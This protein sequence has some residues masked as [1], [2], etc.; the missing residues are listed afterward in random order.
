MMPDS[1]T[2]RDA[3]L[4]PRVALALLLA[5]IAAVA[6]MAAGMATGQPPRAPSPFFWAYAAQYLI[7]TALGLRAA[8]FERPGRARRAW[9]LLA[10]ATGSTALTVI[11]AGLL[12][13]TDASALMALD[14]GALVFYPLVAAALLH[15]GPQ[16]VGRQARVVLDFAVVGVA[17][18]TLG[19]FFW[20]SVVAR[21]PVVSATSVLYGVALPVAAI[22]VFFAALGLTLRYGPRRPRRTD[23]LVIAGV[24][25]CTVTDVGSAFDLHVGDSARLGWALG[26]LLLAAA[27]WQR[28][29]DQLRYGVRLG[30]VPAVLREPRAARA[31]ER[32]S[33]LAYA[34][35]GAVGLALLIEVLPALSEAARV[36]LVGG[37]ALGVVLVVREVTTARA[38]RALTRVREQEAARFRALVQRASEGLVI[39]GLDGT[40]RYHTEPLTT[41]TG[42]DAASLRH[43]FDLIHSGDRDRAAELLGMLGRVVGTTGSVTVRGA[44]GRRTLEITG[45]NRLDEPAIAGIVLGVR[46]ATERQQ[47]AVQLHQAQKMDGLGRL[48]GGIAHDFNNLLTAIIGYAQ[49]AARSG[50]LPDEVSGP[51]REITR[52]GQQAAE[53]TRHLLAF[54]RRQPLAPRVV[55]FGDALHEMTQML[56]RLLRED[57]ELRVREGADVPSVLADPVQLQQMVLNLAVNARDAMP[58][59]G[60][61]A[62]TTERFV[63]DEAYLRTHPEASP[64]LHAVLRVEDTGIGMTPQVQA[65]AFE[66]FFTTKPEGAGTGLGLATVYG[67]VRQAGGHITVTSTPGHG[68][69][70]RILLPAAA[71]VA[72]APRPDLEPRAVTAAEDAGAAGTALLVEDNDAVRALAAAALRD[73]GFE[74]IAVASGTQALVLDSIRR[75]PL[76]LLVTDVVMPGV[77]GIELARTLRQRYPSLPVLFA[78]AYSDRDPVASLDG[79]APTALLLK[80]FTAEELGAASRRLVA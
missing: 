32:P 19:A 6:A 35:I 9:G 74:V 37:L 4:S 57:V 14:A 58:D 47:L 67:V 36:L 22:V 38:H 44:D 77:G 31:S 25:L 75:V 5:Q 26:T 30:G 56:G 1:P 54:S 17:T 80:P 53:L 33:S 21:S 27:A 3:L 11:V 39:V 34:G 18:L 78:T 15:L 65:R 43:L 42:L 62:L 69:T 40:V 46:D 70:F 79:A 12:R 2:T 71:G 7:A 72:A 24:M 48:A 52:A 68:T 23:T 66:P 76:D 10:L 60:V 61:L 20:L 45:I 29:R 64:G 49:L 16:T 59:G 55:H 13:P 41:V 51:L 8:A 50:P 63:P 73:H 28:A